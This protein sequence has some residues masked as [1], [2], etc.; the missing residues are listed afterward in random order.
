MTRDRSMRR[1]RIGVGAAALA[2]AGLAVTAPML[3]YEDVLGPRGTTARW[4]LATA[5]SAEIDAVAS[6]P[7]FEIRRRFTAKVAA[8]LG[9]TAATWPLRLEEMPGRLNLRYGEE[10]SPALVVDI[11]TLKASGMTGDYARR[12][13]HSAAPERAVSA[14]LTTGMF[15]VFAPGDGCPPGGTVEQGGARREEAGP[16]GPRRAAPG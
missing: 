6:E 15:G 2:L 14:V 10:R 4:A 11:G 1:A 16:G 3:R 5:A 7:A 8:C 13:G 9:V 12:S